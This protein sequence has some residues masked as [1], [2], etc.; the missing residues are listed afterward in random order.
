MLGIELQ[1]RNSYKY[2]LTSILA[3]KGLLGKRGKMQMG[4]YMILKMKA[5]SFLCHSEEDLFSRNGYN[6][7]LLYGL[8]MMG[9]E[10]MRIMA[11]EMA[12]I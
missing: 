11:L 10:S 8:F 5:D 12:L 6:K 3:S 9:R 4:L 1:V 7:F 2:A